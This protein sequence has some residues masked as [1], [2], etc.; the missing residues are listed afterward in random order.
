LDPILVVA[1]VGGGVLVF[2]AIIL[3]WMVGT[4]ASRAVGIAVV[5]AVVAIAQWRLI[6][7]GWWHA[8]VA[9]WEVDR[10]PLGITALFGGLIAVVVY[11]AARALLALVRQAR[12]RHPVTGRTF[13]ASVVLLLTF[14]ALLPVVRFEAHVIAAR[15]RGSGAAFRS[16]A[17]TCRKKS[18]LCDEIPSLLGAPPSGGVVAAIAGDTT[19]PP[20]L[21]YELAKSDQRAMPYA[22]TNPHLSA[23]AFRDLTVLC[24]STA[25]DFVSQNPRMPAGVLDS[26]DCAPH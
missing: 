1:L 3:G 6:L 4:P 23:A 19:A 13:A 10:T 14:V 16:L 20:D 25:Q 26:L 11:P 7:G 17:T 5:V 2:C 12:R 24:D 22:L 18:V 21:I 8:P 9:D 15:W